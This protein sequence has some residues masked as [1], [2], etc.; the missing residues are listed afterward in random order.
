MKMLLT[1]FLS[2]LSFSMFAQPCDSNSLVIQPIRA[3][4]T[5]PNIAFELARHYTFYNPACSEKNTLLVHM[6]GTFGDPYQTI[7]FPSLAAN[8]GFHVLSL[9]YPNDTSAQT[10]CGGS[11]DIDCHYKFRKEIFEGVDLSPEIAVDSV[12][13]ISNRLIRLLQHMDSNYQSQNW[14]Q[15]FTGDSIHW[16][17]V[18]LSGHSQGGGHAAVMAIDRPVKR[19]LMFAAPNDFSISFNQTA[20]WTQMPH[21]TEDSAYYS[22]NNVND[23]VA[24]YDWQFSSAVNLGE[25]T[26]GDTVNV[27]SSNC[28]YTFSHN[29]YTDR[30][31]S[32]FTQNHG[33]V[34]NDVNVP[35][36]SN[37][38]PVFQE[39]W[40]YM[41][42]LNCSILKSETLS[43]FAFKIAPNPTGGAI[44]I[45][46]NIDLQRISIFNINGQLIQEMDTDSKE[47]NLDVSFLDVGV[48]LVFLE[49]RSGTYVQSKFVKK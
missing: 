18:I 3:S 47:I 44:T 20:N 12:N 13:S 28:P 30:D 11:N 2:V 35:L 5:D 43:D 26:F 40:A 34:V 36:N 25:G 45:S 22:F 1:T 39:V 23:Q 46:G 38:A 48:Y 19:V 31:S 14:G 15:Y 37:G 4:D 6:V 33:M 7:Y 49:D 24:Q 29:L 32:G 10:A 16:S 9:K 27:E 8:N 41:L 17:Q 21:I 42:G